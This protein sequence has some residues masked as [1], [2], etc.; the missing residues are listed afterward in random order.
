MLASERTL[1]ARVSALLGLSMCRESWRLAREPVLF[2]GMFDWVHEA[3]RL[4][5]GR[6]SRPSSLD[7][8]DMECCCIQSDVLDAEKW[9]QPCPCEWCG[10]PWVDWP[11]CSRVEQKKPIVIDVPAMIPVGCVWSHCKTWM[12]ED[13][14]VWVYRVHPDHVHD[15]PLQWYSARLAIRKIRPNLHVCFEMT[16]ADAGKTLCVRYAFS[17]DFILEM[18]APRHGRISL[19]SVETVLRWQLGLT[20]Q[21]NIISH[22]QPPVSFYPS[23]IESEFTESSAAHI[24]E[25]ESELSDFSF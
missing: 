22:E 11:E 18:C 2:S 16:D 6:R 5:I 12:V 13:E 8:Q 1:Q 10:I 9:E 20:E 7:P 15:V 17:G 14:Q 19:G 23:D 4:Q 21:Q 3:L 24:S 25:D